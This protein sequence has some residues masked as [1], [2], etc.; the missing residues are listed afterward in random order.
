MFVG[1]HPI[2]TKVRDRVPTYYGEDSCVENCIVAD[3]CIIEGTVRDSV[4]FR[5]VSVGAG[6]NID[7]CVIM[8]DSVIGEGCELK[9][10]IL[11]K[12]VV[13]H[14]GAKLIGTP[15]NPVIIKRGDSV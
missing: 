10:V 9:C 2:Y 4:L 15:N 7:S 12:D 3:G 8:N 6:C 1:N 11:D 14:P 5:T 13:V